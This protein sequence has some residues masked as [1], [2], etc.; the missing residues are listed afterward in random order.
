MWVLITSILICTICIY[1]LKSSTKSKEKEPPGLYSLKLINK[2][3][4][5]E[6]ANKLRSYSMAD[7]REF[8]TCGKNCRHKKSCPNIY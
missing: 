5:S 8:C 4:I 2:Y 6:Y 7:S 1:F 3:V